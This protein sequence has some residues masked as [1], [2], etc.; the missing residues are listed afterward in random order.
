M[1]DGHGG[2]GGD[3]SSF[4]AYQA[5]VASTKGVYSPHLQQANEDRQRKFTFVDEV[6]GSECRKC[7]IWKP[8]SEFG[9]EKSAPRGIARR[10]KE[11]TRKRGL[12]S[13]HKNSESI[14]ARRRTEEFRVEQRKYEQSWS[15]NRLSSDPCFKLAKYSRA[16]INRALRGTCKEYSLHILIGCTLEELR[17]YL[18]SQFI[19]GMSWDNYGRGGWEVDHIRP[20]ASFDLSDPEQQKQCFNYKNLQPL[21]GI[22]NWKKHAKWEPQGS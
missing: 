4:P 13:Y 5:H 10:C 17:S 9:R 20:C 18:E 14:N 8:L 19:A 2:P 6:E 22:D 21:W 15:K 11:C 1:S 7:L 12:E 16:R 3:R